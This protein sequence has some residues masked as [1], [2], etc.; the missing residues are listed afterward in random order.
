MTA[1]Y[2][3]F[4]IQIQITWSQVA[5]GVALAVQGAAPGAGPTGGPGGSSARK[6]NT[7]RAAG[8]TVTRT[9][10]TSAGPKVWSRVKL[11]TVVP[12]GSIIGLSIP[13]RPLSPWT[14]RTGFLNA[15]VSARRAPRS[16][17]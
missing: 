13:K 9:Q 16:P 3:L 4:S 12:S 5:G 2:G 1:L 8:S 10:A 11:G 6:E 14:R 7:S 15:I 17:L